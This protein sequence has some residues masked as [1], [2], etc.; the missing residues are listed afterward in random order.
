[1]IDATDRMIR[2]FSNNAIVVPGKV[3]I[4]IENVILVVKDRSEAVKTTIIK[5]E[6]KLDEVT[7]T[8][9]YLVGKR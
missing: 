4:E 3:P 9:V 6:G 1:M 5:R 8:P 2:V 7:F